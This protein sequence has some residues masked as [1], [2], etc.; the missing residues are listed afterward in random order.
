MR[1]NIHEQ[2]FE[3]CVK[4]IALVDDTLE[5]LG[6]PKEYRR[7][8]NSVIWL[9]IMWLGLVFLAT[10]GDALWCMEIYDDQKAIIVPLVMDY[11]VHVNSL[12]DMIFMFLMW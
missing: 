10:S 6:T 3:I 5:E 9:V 2:S 1:K 12:T 7:I 8:R 4:R 11:P